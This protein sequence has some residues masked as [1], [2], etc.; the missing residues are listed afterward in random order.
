MFSGHISS[1]SDD[2][3]PPVSSTFTAGAEAGITAGSGTVGRSVGVC[4][5]SL[6][7]GACT[8]DVLGLSIT[9]GERMAESCGSG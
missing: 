2:S 6:A 3:A 4:C 1:D 7:G 9:V 5:H 8:D